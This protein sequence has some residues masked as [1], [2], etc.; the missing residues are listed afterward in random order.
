MSRFLTYTFPAGNTQDVCLSQTLTGTGNLN[1]NGNLVNPLNKQVSF[2]QKGYSRQISLTSANDLSAKTFTI[3][4]IQNGVVISETITGPNNNIV[5]ST[6]IYDVINSISVNGAV[7]NIS[8]GTGFSG[9]FP[10]IGI[11]LEKDVVNYTLTIARLTDA[12]VSFSVYGTLDRVINNGKTYSDNVSNNKNLFQIQAPDTTA[13]FVYSGLTGIY[14]YILVQL[15]ATSG[16]IDKS[17]KL[18]FIQ[19]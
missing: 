13:N 9:F 19:T 18:N 6:Q 5:Y 10:L 2:I 15:G 1:L 4:G 12:S 3:N 17:M 11:N 7:T 14:A 16:T 8:V